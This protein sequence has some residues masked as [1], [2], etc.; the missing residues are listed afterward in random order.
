[1]KSRINVETVDFTEMESCCLQDSFIKRGKV[2]LL[3]VLMVML[4]IRKT[5]GKIT[6]FGYVNTFKYA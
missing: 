6:T 3:K 5:R 2:H 4:F 1:M